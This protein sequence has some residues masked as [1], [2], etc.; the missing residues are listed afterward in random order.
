LKQALD[1]N[2]IDLREIDVYPQNWRSFA[3]DNFRLPA[4]ASFLDSVPAPLLKT[5]VSIIS[6]Y[7][8]ADMKKC[9]LCKKCVR[10]CPKQVISITRNRQLKF[11]YKKCIM[12]M[13]CSEACAYGAIRVRQTLIFKIL[14]VVRNIV[15]RF[16]FQ[17]KE[18]K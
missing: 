10:I 13:C 7:P 18:R 12:C 17:K 1:E 2:L 15:S 14:R 3:I 4:Q 16:T 8:Q 11:N 9:V 6:F 5:V